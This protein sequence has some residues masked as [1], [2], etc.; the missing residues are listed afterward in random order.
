MAE[1]LD[2]PVELSIALGALA[3][4]YFALGLLSEHVQVELRRL[5]LYQGPRFDDGTWDC[6]L[7]APY[8]T[9]GG[10]GSGSG[11]SIAAARSY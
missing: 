9:N 1:Q 7:C 8:Q 10:S 3:T 5:A 2:S 6:N 4:A 11:S